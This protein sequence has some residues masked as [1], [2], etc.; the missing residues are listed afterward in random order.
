MHKVVLFGECML[1]LQGEAFGSMHQGFGGDTLNTAVY[2]ARCATELQVCYATALGDDSLSAGM[3]QR[4]QAERLDVSLVQ[5]LPGRMP[6]LYLIQVDDQGER[7]FSYWRD[8]SAAKAYFDAAIT[9]LEAEADSLDAFYISGISLAILPPAGRERLFALM[10][11]LRARGATVVFDNNYRPRLWANR[12]EALANFDRAYALAS[13]ALITADDEQ[14]L[15]NLPTLQAAVDAAQALPCAEVVVKRGRDA[16]LVRSASGVLEVPT[17][18]VDKVVDT[19]AAGDS[20][21][22]GYLA[23]R[24]QGGSMADA[25]RHGNRLAGRVI[26][27]RGAL[28]PQDVMT[29]LVLSK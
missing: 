1:E 17:E 3:L 12:E 21:A 8:S 6:G 11:R 14:A 19:T 5:R 24:L 25:A 9:P 20:F 23:V 15:R 22:A 18:R 4:W 16:T 28:I 26:Q 13:I 7:S 10:G 2:L 27:H 29:D